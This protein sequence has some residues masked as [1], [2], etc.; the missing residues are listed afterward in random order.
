MRA[1]VG[2]GLCVTLLASAGSTRA[3]TVTAGNVNLRITGR[4]QFQFNTTSVADDEITS[5]APASLAGSSFETRRVR[6][7]LQLRVDDW[8][9]GLVEPDFALGRF[10]IRQAWMNLAF[11]SAFELK[12]GQFK[13]PFSQI[14]LTSSTEISAIER[15]QRIRGLYEYLM[16]QDEAAAGPTVLS[17]L[18]G[19][20]LM[21][22]EHDL[23]DTQGYLAYEMGAS[24]HGVI[25]AFDYDAGIF[26]GSGPD[27]RDEN[28]GK[29]LAG[30]LRWRPPSSV[31]LAVSAAASYH[32]MA[33]TTTTEVEGTAYMLDFELGAFK[34]GGPH[35]IAE[36]VTGENLA[37]DQSFR[38]AQA[39]LSLYRPV[40]HARV[41][42][43]EPV[44]RVSWADPNVAVD[45]DEGA[46]L[47]PGLNIYFEG[48]NR[49][50]LNWDVFAPSGNRFEMKHALRAQAQLT[51]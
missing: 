10:T 8:I 21:A 38:G 24:V 9:T 39:M 6:T 44:A 45:G 7:A 33:L 12:M 25:G 27:R 26:N 43:I 5:G 16:V 37:A 30:R 48:R 23:L 40:T 3:Q 28:D 15:G 22:E 51:W 13:K 11:D 20:P 19:V 14:F 49:F 31:P 18:R 2:V 17:V 46:F 4:M 47:T 29:S 32:E 41:D 50:M 36:V 42:G 35:L 1:A 34:R